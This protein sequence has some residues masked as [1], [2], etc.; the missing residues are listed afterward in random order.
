M[1]DGVIS[2]SAATVELISLLEQAGPFGAGNTEPRFA[3]GSVRIAKADVVGGDHVRCFLAGEDGARLK[4]IAFRV[5]GTELG[6]ALAGT[7]GAALHLA[8]RLRLDSWRGATSAQL[9]IEDAAPT[10]SSG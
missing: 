4:G 6:R 10:H 5:A 2:P 8:G 3:L 7:A 1:I 9:H